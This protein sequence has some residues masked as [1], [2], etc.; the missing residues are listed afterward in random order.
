MKIWHISDTHCKHRELSVPQCDLVVHSGD[1][2]NSRKLDIN[3]NETVD[4]LEWYGSLDIKH[5]ILVPGNHDVALYHKRVTADKIPQNIIYL[6]D[7]EAVIEGVK[8]YGSPHTPTHGSDQWAW[9]HDRSKLHKYWDN[10]PEDTDILITHGPPFGILDKAW[11]YLNI[12]EGKTYLYPKLIEQT[13][14]ANLKRKVDEVQPMLHLF[15]HLHDSRD[16][17]NSGIMKITPTLYSNASCVEDGT[18]QV[19]NNGNIIYIDT[20]IITTASVSVVKI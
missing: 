15:G 19:S 14:C 1:F 3:Y 5:K 20:D 10:I 18:L 17:I 12:E 4:F 13:G 6:E 9:M 11:R 16:I 2:S 7:K 8:I